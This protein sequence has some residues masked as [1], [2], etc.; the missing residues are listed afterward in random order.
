MRLRIGIDVEEEIAAGIDIGPVIV[1]AEGVDYSLAVAE[2]VEFLPGVARHH[3]EVRLDGLE[4]LLV[5]DVEVEKGVA[6]DLVPVVLRACAILVVAA[7]CH[8]RVLGYGVVRPVLRHLVTEIEVEVEFRHPVER[9]VDLEVTVAGEGLADVLLLVEELER[10]LP[11]CGCFGLAGG[12]EV[13]VVTV[14]HGLVE[15]SLGR[16]AGGGVQFADGVDRSCGHCHPHHV[17]AVAGADV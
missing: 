14:E 10:V 2:I 12:L 4:I 1:V 8:D 17:G 15:R 13:V 16:V 6:L 7:P 11:V 9:I 3:V 5:V